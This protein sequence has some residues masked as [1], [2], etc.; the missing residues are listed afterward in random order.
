MRAMAAP[1]AARRSGAARAAIVG[2]GVEPGRA[3]MDHHRLT[4][5]VAVDALLLDHP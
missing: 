1:Q 5:P 4:Q 3:H 2:E